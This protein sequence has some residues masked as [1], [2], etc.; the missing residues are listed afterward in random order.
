LNK[1]KGR[2]RKKGRKEDGMNEDRKP[3]KKETHG[4]TSDHEK[5]MLIKKEKKLNK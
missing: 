2:I 1:G 3:R 5:M 4:G